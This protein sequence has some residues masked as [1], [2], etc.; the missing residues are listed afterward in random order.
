MGLET[1]SFVDDL[2]ATNPAGTDGKNQGDDHLRLIKSALKATFIGATRAYHFSVAGA[3]KVGAYTI[4]LTDENALI[5]ANATSGDFTITLPLGSTVFAGFI[6]AVMKTDSSSGTVTVDGSGAETIN[7]SASRDLDGQFVSETYMWD[8]GEWKIVATYTEMAQLTVGDGVEVSSGALRV[9]L[10]DTSIGRGSSG[11][12]RVSSRSR[13]TVDYIALAAD[14]GTLIEMDK[15]T[16]IT[17]NLT[18][19]ATLGDGWFIDVNSSGAGPCTIDPDGAEL[20]DDASTILLLQNKSTRIVCDGSAFWTVG[21]SNFTPSFTSS[22]QTVTAN[23]RLDVAH[24]LGVKPSLVQL[25]LICKEGDENYSVGDEILYN[26]VLHFSSNSGVVSFYDATNVS[27]IQGGA[28][29]VLNRST[30]VVSGIT[31]GRWRW[32]VKAWL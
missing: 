14:N 8:G 27:I 25:T 26:T 31:T 18:A 17:L 13:K 19:A 7:E 6:V 20:I 3:A 28:I 16:A 4:V 24:G 2:V 9:K 30:F 11:I 1:V 22:E 32:I 23:T 10:E 29:V 21:R 12:K 5:R 15:A